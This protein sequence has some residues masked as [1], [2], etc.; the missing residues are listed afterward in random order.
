MIP[1][2][3]SDEGTRAANAAAGRRLTTGTT[4]TG[5]GTS[6][7]GEAS[8]AGVAGGNTLHPLLIPPEASALWS[9]PFMA[10]GAAYGVMAMLLIPG[11]PRERRPFSRPWRYNA[12]ENTLY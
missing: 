10:Y 5:S 8:E 7:A 1:K 9:R 11:L 12:A 2:A 6:Y 3:E 4:R